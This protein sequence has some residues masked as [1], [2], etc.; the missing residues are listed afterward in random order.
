LTSNDKM[1]DFTELFDSIKSQ[2]ELFLNEWKEEHRHDNYDHDCD[3][4]DFEKDEEF[5]LEKFFLEYTNSDDSLEYYAISDDDLNDSYREGSAWVIKKMND[6]YGLD[7][8]D[9]SKTLTKMSEDNRVYAK[10]LIYWIGCEI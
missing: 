6:E 1:S 8:D 2:I 4:Y 7:A 3:G 10:Q 5:L 9:I